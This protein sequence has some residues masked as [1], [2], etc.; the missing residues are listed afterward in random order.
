MEV[1]QLAKSL[2]RDG[3]LNKAVAL[4]EEHMASLPNDL[5]VAAAL[6][7]LYMRLKLPEK[8]AYWL[9][10]SLQMMK[11]TVQTN[12]LYYFDQFFEFSSRFCWLFLVRIP[13]T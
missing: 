10:Y 4:L 11:I 7:R 3:N 13:N 12:L 5:T 1:L 2:S 9:R 8:A 6:G